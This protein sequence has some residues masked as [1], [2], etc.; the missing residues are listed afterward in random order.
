M[1]GLST[2][3]PRGKTELPVRY[4]QLLEEYVV[5]AAM[6]P[7]G[8]VCALGLGDGRVRMLDPSSGT[9]L[10]EVQAHPGGVLGLAVS[11]D[12]STVVSGGQEDSARLWSPRGQALGVLPCAGDGWVELVAWSADGLYVATAAGR[13]VRVWTAR[14]EPVLASDPLPSTI[15]G[16][17]FRPDGQAVAVAC[18]GGVHVFTLAAGESARHFPWKGSL[19]SLA[20]SPDGRVIASATQDGSVH[21]WRV[22]SGKDAQMTGY[23]LKPKAL[24]WDGESK[25]L[26]TSGGDAVTVWDFRGGGPEGTRPIELRAHKA[27]VSV[28]AFAPR[29]GLLASG[30]RDT[31][32]L[33]WAPRKGSGPVRYAFLEDEVSV[34]AWH[35]RAPVLL[36]ADISGTLRGF[37]VG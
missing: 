26:A 13:R 6:A 5:C 3:P 23:P 9:T 14:G 30:G 34:L 22:A 32:L 37:A 4:E 16:L 28:L 21:F 18:Y 20:W 24:A 17:Q 29:S 11:P 10:G 19:V 35:P 27:A 2:S 25:L 8:S 7:S 31:S 33:L 36:A 15:R 12:G 1:S